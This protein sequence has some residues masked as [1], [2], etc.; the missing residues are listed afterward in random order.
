MPDMP[1][2]SIFRPFSFAIISDLHLAE[3]DGIER[4]IRFKQML[5]GWPEV[6]FVL[7]TGDIVWHGERKE[8]ESLLT[9]PGGRPLHILYGNNDWEQIGVLEGQWGPRY[10][11]F[12]YQGCLFVLSWNCMPA[13][14]R[15]NHRGFWEPQ[16]AD[17]IAEQFAQGRRLDLRHLFFAAHVPPFHPEGYF[18]RFFMFENGARQFY[19][20]C[21]KYLLRAG[22]FGHIHQNL[23]WRHDNTEVIVMPSLNWNFQLQYGKPVKTAG[24]ACRI[25]HVCEN[26][27]HEELIPV[28]LS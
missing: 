26:H 25:I 27:I 21:E 14:A 2:Q 10:H 4:L 22:F 20:W 17:W 13:D 3:D 23:H 15:E 24:G 18:E 19:Q 8:L 6:H 1:E 5:A 28:V 7:L 16:Q 12:M 11:R 9:M